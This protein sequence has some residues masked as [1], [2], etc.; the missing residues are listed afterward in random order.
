MYTDDIDWKAS[1]I[2]YRN[3]CDHARR[4]MINI[5]KHSKDHLSRRVA[6]EYARNFIPEAYQ[7][8]RNKV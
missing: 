7:E 4:Y 8:Y 6:I 3:E 1:A 2:S 5:L